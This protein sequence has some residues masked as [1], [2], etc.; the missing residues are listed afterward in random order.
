MCN[1]VQSEQHFAVT[2]ANRLAIFQAIL[3]LV[4][5]KAGAQLLSWDNKCFTFYGLNSL[6]EGVDENKSNALNL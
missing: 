3:K 4:I 1:K 5:E 6:H 2:S